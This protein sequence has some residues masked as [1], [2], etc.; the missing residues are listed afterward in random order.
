MVSH[1]PR[2]AL[3]KI[4]LIREPDAPGG[5]E[6][7]DLSYKVLDATYHN[8]KFWL[9]GESVQSIPKWKYF[10]LVISSF[11]FN[12]EWW[13]ERSG[14]REKLAFQSLEISEFSWIFKMFSLLHYY[15]WRVSGCFNIWY[16]RHK[17]VWSGRGKT[18]VRIYETFIITAEKNIKQDA[19]KIKL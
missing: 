5:M 8:T 4:L 1:L 16:K 14:S 19:A 3:G 6:A 2:H 15:V 10:H 17:R 9:N 11:R 7:S 12:W 13:N 18:N